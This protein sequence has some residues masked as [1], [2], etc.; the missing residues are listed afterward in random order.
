MGVAS[1]LLLALGSVSAGA[2]VIR[3]YYSVTLSEG[4][5]YNGTRMLHSLGNAWF[6]DETGTPVYNTGITFKWNHRIHREGNQL[7]ILSG[8]TGTASDEMRNV[9]Q[10]PVAPNCWQ[11]RLTLYDFYNANGPIGGEFWEASSIPVCPTGCE[12]HHPY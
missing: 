11:A 8:S 3:F 1:L 7:W 10:T 9:I 5:A 6:G 2:Q 4:V 12:P